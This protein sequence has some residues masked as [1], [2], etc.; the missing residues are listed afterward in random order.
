MWRKKA[1]DKKGELT[2]GVGAV[3]TERKTSRNE[4]KAER[5][6]ERAL[7]GDEDNIDALLA[8]F[9]LQPTRMLRGGGQRRGTQSRRVDPQ[10]AAA[11]RHGGG[12]E[13]VQLGVLWPAAAL[14]DESSRLVVFRQPP[15]CAGLRQ[16][17]DKAKKEV[18]IEADCPPPSPRVNGSLVP[19]ITPKSSELILFGG[20]YTDLT[21]G[22]VHVNADLYRF[23]VDKAKW[24]RVKAPSSPSPRCAHQAVVYKGCMYV[25]G[26]EFSSPNQERF[27]HFRDLWRLDL[28]TH[29]WDSL[30]TRGGPSA[31]S[32]HRMALHKNKA[33][34]FGGFYDTGSEVK[35]YSD[36]WELDLSELTWRPVGP[37]PAP[38]GAPPPLAPAPRSGCGLAVAG[39]VMYV[40]G[41][42]SKEGDDEDDELEHGRAHDDMWALDLGSYTW[43]RVKK[44]GMAPG[45]RASFG[46]A[47]HKGAR[48]FLFGGVSDNE[49]KGGEDL[50][51]EFHNDLY[52]F[53]CTNRRW[54]G[55]EL[56]PSKAAAKQQ[57][58]Q[59]EAAAAV[60][61]GEPGGSGGGGGAGAAAGSSGSGASGGAAAGDPK[62]A[63][64]L[65]AGKDKNSPTYKAAVRIQSRF[66][67]F[68][69]RKAYQLYKVGGVVSEL[70]Y[71]PAAYGL[72]MSIRNMP[73]PRARISPQIAV[74]GNAMWLL[75]GTVE[76]GDKEIT[77]DD[78]WRLDLQKLDGWT[79]VQENT[80]GEEVFKAAAAAAGQSSEEEED[81]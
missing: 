68:V 56:R 19:Y 71:S 25:F 62:I 65:A 6:A 73:K 28:S 70:L 39:D 51:S 5:R 41:G 42:Y 66:R 63:A 54:F 10:G 67:G 79:L 50:S 24:T 43:E 32:G 37:P 18:V 35:Y 4:L 45:P 61:S 40:Y 7:E 9:A 20:E 16:L 64:L 31:R 17:L 47:V 30:P 36:L 72:D 3:K 57:Q 29:E 22:K 78:M 13:R 12:P 59:E 77:L 34:L 58:Q 81:G 11:G 38:L 52:T 15:S 46:W 55:A 49:A 44:Q 76:V 14:R 26:G 33:I 53:S 69:V 48:A 8:Q 2:S 27:M 74:V 1:K 60:G 23:D 75:G 80:V 21:T